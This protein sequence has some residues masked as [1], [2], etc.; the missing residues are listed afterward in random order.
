MRK[1]NNYK[2][3]LTINEKVYLSNTI[4]KKYSL[5]VDPY[6]GVGQF[7]LDLRGGYNDIEMEVQ[8]Y[9]KIEDKQLIMRLPSKLSHLPEKLRIFKSILK[10]IT[11]IFNKNQLGYE[12]TLD[13]IKTERPP[14][15]EYTLLNINKELSIE[16]F[17][18]LAQTTKI[19]NAKIKDIG[20]FD[21]LIY[22][23]N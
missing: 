15:G 12:F 3:F 20:D 2:G 7:R 16:D 8:M 10:D 4:F 23:T 6:S 19:M 18:R 1:I 9:G 21:K 17:E 13:E 14:L 11:Y 22:K 5:I